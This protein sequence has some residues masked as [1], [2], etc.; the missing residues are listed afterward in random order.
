MSPILFLSWL[1]VASAGTITDSTKATI[2]A[3]SPKRIV[4]VAGN[5]SETVFALGLGGSVVGVDATSL[6]PEAVHRLPKVGYY[7][8]I[9]AEGILA[10]SPDLIIATDT[11]G[12][13]NVIAQ[14]RGSGVPIAILDSDQ[15]FDGAQKRI[16][17]IAKLL[18]RTSEGEALTQAMQAE[19]DTMVK[20]EKAP[21]V[22]F[23]YAR[24]AG[25]QNVSGTDTAANA[26]IELAG[27]K[28]AVTDYT[29]Y[30]P[31]N[32][33]AMIQAN[34]DYILFTKR[35]LQSIGGVD[36]ASKLSGVAQTNAGKN[37]KIIAVDDLVLLGFGPRTSQGAIE[38]SKAISE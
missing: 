8:D 31:M 9:N 10:L 38:L 15:S 16:T 4:T 3:D 23:I 12:P 1:G 21:T 24:G 32:A 37:K 7:R 22:M 6:Y 30:K 28:N 14:I 26:M 25:T 18:D 35:G 13:P 5:V 20:P 36:A 11:A 33:E 2:T 27:G 29:G 19:I 17:Q 34:P